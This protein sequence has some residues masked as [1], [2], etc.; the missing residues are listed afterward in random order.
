MKE[1]EQKIWIGDWDLSGEESFRAESHKEF[2]HELPIVDTLGDNRSLQLQSNRRDFLKYLGFGLGAA[3]IAASCE[4]PLK[5][6]IPYVIKPDDIVPGVANYYA[7]SFVQG[8]DYCSILVKTREGRPIKIEGND[9]SSVTKGGTSARAQAAVLSLYD[10]NRFRAPLK[11]S[12]DGDTETTWEALDKQISETLTPTSRV[13]ILTGTIMSPTSKKAI[14]EFKARY[15]N[16]QVISYDAVSSA[17]LLKANEQ[18][19]G[20]R[21]IPDYHFDKAK[22]VVGIQADFLGTWISPVEYTKDYIINR[23]VNDPKHAEMSR[24]YQVESYF[25]LTGSKADN[26]I[27]IRPSEAGAAVAHVYNAVASATGGTTISAPQL[28]P[29]AAAALAKVGRTLASNRGQ[30]LVV[31]G[32]N[33]IGEQ[34]LV[35]RINDLLGNYGHTL[36]FGAVNNKRQGDESGVRQ[37]TLD[38]QGNQVDALFLWGANP[39]YDLPNGQEIAEAIATV[40]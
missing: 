7:S 1:T 28:D 36:D 13:R 34:T 11:R 22:V 23:K 29:E 8:G 12:A 35:N 14:D 2:N 21:G 4:I 10:T 24:H 31:C 39:V 27:Q 30:S 33:N 16:T 37:L 20:V 5:R 25:S 9:L 32:T 15:P 6:V 19:F 3:T 40:P 17:A 18:C 26:R 38:M